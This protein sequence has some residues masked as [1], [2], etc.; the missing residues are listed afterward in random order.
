MKLKD[1]YSERIK[2]REWYNLYYQ[3]GDN[4][5]GSI[6]KCFGTNYRNISTFEYYFKEFKKYVGKPR[7]SWPKKPT[8]GQEIAKQYVVNMV[9]SLLYISQRTAN[10]DLIYTL[11]SRGKDFEKMISIDF[12]DFEKKFL[13]FVFIMN[14]SF[15]KT[16]R[17]LLKT[18]WNVLDKWSAA[19]FEDNYLSNA[20]KKFIIE[21]QEQKKVEE[22][23]SYDIVWLLSFYTDSEFLKLFK[24]SSIKDINE[25]KEQTKADY[26]NQNKSNVLAWKYKSTNFQKPMLI[27][28]LLMI[29]LSDII[30]KCDT[31]EISFA[32]F[33]EVLVANYSELFNVDSKKILTFIHNNENVFKVIFK[34][35][36]SEEDDFTE[37]YVP[38]YRIN[39][40]APIPTEKI[41]STSQEGIEKLEVVR[42]VLKKLAKD[43]SNYQCALHNLN[44]CTYFTSKEENKNYL[45]IHHLVPR[46]FSYN[47]DDTIE[48]VENYI[49]L[50]PR[51]H[52]MIHKAVDG[53]RI[54]L[55]NYL[56]NQRNEDLSKQNIKI[57]IKELYEFY[58]IDKK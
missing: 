21:Q 37:H 50:C 27:D 38:E 51:C 35:A 54:S 10:S 16:P 12:D 8:T 33:Y 44:N 7:S 24:V 19:G 13:L 47:F 34:N 43:K 17:Y 25:L 53:E 26:K 36:T 30:R 9:S 15:K 55:I 1:Y 58:K 32:E 52:R 57:T 39:I 29:Y 3:C 56:F 42:A 14:S 45:E 46:E 48:F 18:S 23:F 40:N 20:I 4:F 22:I 6:F 11:S 5:D 28:T 31:R 49:P 2:N 41:D